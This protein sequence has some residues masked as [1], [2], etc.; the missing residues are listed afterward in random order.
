MT[1]AG[2]NTLAVR[3]NI[4][5]LKFPIQLL[6]ARQISSSYRRL[7][8]VGLLFITAFGVRLYHSNEPPLGFHATRQYRSLIIARGY[9]FDSSTAIPE[10]KKQV[11]RINKERQGILEPPLMETLVA[12][13]YR[14]IGGENFWIPRLLSSLFWITGGGFLYLI[15]RKIAG[16]NAALFSMAFYLFLPFAVSASR[17]FQP[18]PLM[19][20]LL[21]ASVYSIL[22]VYENRSA[23]WLIACYVL[24]GS[25]IFVKP[26]SLFA[27][28]TVFGLLAIYK[29]GVKKSVTN[30]GLALFIPMTLLPGLIFYLYGILAAGVLQNQVQASFLPQLLIT[31]FFWR[32]WLNNIR[33]VIGFP[34]LIGSL[35]GVLLLQNGLT[36]LPLV[37]LWSGYA[38]FCLVFNYHIATHDYYHL[39]LIPIIALSLGPVAALIFERLQEVNQEWHWRMAIGCVLSLALVLSLTVARANLTN[40][41]FENKVRS[42]QEIGELVQHNTNTVYLS[43][44]YGLSLQYH[45]ELSG[46]PWPLTSDL[47][48]ERLAGVPMPDAETRFRQMFAED[49][50]QYFI[51][52]DLGELEQQEDLKELLAQDYAVLAEDDNYI[53]YELR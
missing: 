4:T 48:W 24:S 2:N 11:A 29:F 17:S 53:V 36:K 10:S 34:A 19:V 52:Q 1:L 14:L 31:P 42:A 45:G 40:P 32:G 22:R 43:G 23:F 16:E 33:E 3:M 35:I 50:P 41:G 44:D 27:I 26:V 47:E 51:V 6:Q 18:D 25:A 39:Q 13:G 8:L 12:I 9:Y 28:Y 7:L 49:L 15:A 21:L 38:L 46:E 5:Q 37:G 20:L 30:L